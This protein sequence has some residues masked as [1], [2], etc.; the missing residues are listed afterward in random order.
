M[1]SGNIKHFTAA[2]FTMS[3]FAIIFLF[4]IKNSVSQVTDYDSLKY[5]TVLIGDKAWTT[6]NLNTSHYRNGDAIP[7][8]EDSVEWAG[9]TTGAWCYYENNSAN[10][11]TYGKLYNW[12]ALTDPRGL[13][14]VGW[15]VST[16]ADWTKLISEAGDE[17]AALGLLSTKIWKVQKKD[18]TNE[19][20]F[21]ATPGGGRLKAGTFLNGGV[22]CCY[23]T[24]TE[25]GAQLAYSRYIFSDNLTAARYSN[26]KYFGFSVRCV[27]DN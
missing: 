15:H 22:Y 20:G 27:K 25:S 26:A 13:A 3:L 7:Q 2:I 21:T 5:R 8:V 17:D 4:G 24:S 10:G 19:T 16:D 12:Y 18:V 14:P 6:E 1:K 23:W 9:L 11:K